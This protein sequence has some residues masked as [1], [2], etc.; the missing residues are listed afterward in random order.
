M[1]Y[2]WIC[3]DLK[4]AIFKQNFRKFDY[5][6]SI[7]K[8]AVGYH[9]NITLPN[10]MKCIL[11]IYCMWFMGNTYAIILNFYLEYQNMSQNHKNG[12]TTQTSNV[13]TARLVQA[14]P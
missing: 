10:W 7:F 11:V 8:I 14:P 13:K 4:N 5:L 2:S 9:G 12:Q 1:L 6:I 3:V